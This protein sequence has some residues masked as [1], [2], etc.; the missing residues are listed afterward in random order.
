MLSLANPQWKEF[1]D[2]VE[3]MGKKLRTNPDG[4]VRDL[5]TMLLLAGP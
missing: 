1:L 5:H 3:R 2:D 4:D